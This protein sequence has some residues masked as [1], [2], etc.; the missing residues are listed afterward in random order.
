MELMYINFLRRLS[1]HRVLMHLLFW[2]AVL[3]FFNFVFRLGRTV[4][5][6]LIDSILFLPGHLLFVYSLN[7]FLFPRY[8]LKGKLLQAFAGL[9]VILAIALFYM[10]F[11][12]VYY[13]HYSGSGRLWKPDYF[14]RAIYSLFS[15]GWIAVTIRLVK[16]W[17]IEKET[18]HRLEKE[19]LTVELQLLRSQLH[20]HFLFNTLNSLY[21][22]TLESSKA[23][24]GAVLQLSS[25]LR[26]ILYECNDPLVSLN[27]EIDSL[28]HYIQ[29]EKMRFGERLEI[30]LSFT[31]DL[32]NRSIAPLLFL[33]FVENSIK[34]GISEQLDKSWISLHLHVEGQ[35]LTF[36]LINSRASETAPG[37]ATRPPVAR[38][39]APATPR[40]SGLGLLNVRRRL[41]LLYPDCHILKLTPDEDT[42][43]VSLT[44]HFDTPHQITQTPHYYETSMSVG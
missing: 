4:T 28:K 12:D 18:Q 2:A 13:I 32:A 17:Y 35:T 34:H 30:S 22:L 40:S 39:V 5:K 7:Y 42:F 43:M 44:I 33:P 31:G 20:P 9:F 1:R 23:A 29:L 19:K 24:P 14:P 15:V 11:A 26:Y 36:K 37:S 25:L 8:V 3:L 16:Y 38:L 10:R 41:D 27:Q 6:T 21:A